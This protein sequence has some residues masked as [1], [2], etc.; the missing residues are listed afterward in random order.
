MTEMIEAEPALA[1]RILDAR[2]NRRQRRRASSAG[3]SGR[4]IAAGDPVIVTG[5]GTSEHAAQGVAEIL[6]EA[7]RGGRPHGPGRLARPRAGSPSRPSS[8][9]STRRRPGS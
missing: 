7:V 2:T 1:E 3:P 6:R 4:A 9:R 8:C 5:C